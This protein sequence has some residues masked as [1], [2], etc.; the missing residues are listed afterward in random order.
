MKR[1]SYGLRKHLR[2]MKAVIRKTDRDLQ[3]QEE[4]IAELYTKIVYK[5]KK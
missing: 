3:K 1:F 4:K 2:K 5:I